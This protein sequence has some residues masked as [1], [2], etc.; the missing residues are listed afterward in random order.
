VSAVEI[1][2]LVALAIVVVLLITGL[3]GS[4]R[5]EGAEAPVFDRHLLEADEALER[6][7]AAD[8]GWERE[9]L[10][11]AARRA[12]TEARPS[13]DYDELHLI[14][15]DD[16]EGVEADRAHFLA[17][18]GPDEARVVLARRDGSWATESVQ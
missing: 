13:W 7:R 12:L 16:R 2:A 15:V 3:A 8:R 10:D 5:R 6:A 17:R 18:S 1:I 14:L 9:T 11:R 4:R